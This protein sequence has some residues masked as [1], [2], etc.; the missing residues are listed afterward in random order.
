MVGRRHRQRHAPTSLRHRRSAPVAGESF[1][2]ALSSAR[3]A[4]CQRDPRSRPVRFSRGDLACVPRTRR[5]F[6]EGACHTRHPTTQQQPEPTEE[7]I[8]RRPDPS[9]VRATARTRLAV[10]S[11]AVGEAWGRLRLPGS[12]S[13]TT[14]RVTTSD[15]TMSRRVGW[16]W[17]GLGAFTARRRPIHRVT[18]PYPDEFSATDSTAFVP[19]TSTEFGSAHTTRYQYRTHSSFSNVFSAQRTA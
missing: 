12:E 5:T 3:R 14:R 1:A 15:D 8:C 4:D 19:P 2:L 13:S 16:D 17:T 7:A 11:S 9:S 6:C 10:R 18:R